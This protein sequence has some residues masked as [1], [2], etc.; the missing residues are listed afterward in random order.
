MTELAMG[1]EIAREWSFSQ[2]N[3]ALILGPVAATQPYEV[4]KDIHSKEDFQKILA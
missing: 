2:Q 3:Y 1:K 4:D